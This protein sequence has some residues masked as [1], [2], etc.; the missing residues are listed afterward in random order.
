MREGVCRRSNLADLGGSIVVVALLSWWLR[1]IF[2]P[3]AR[4]RRLPVGPGAPAATACAA[5]RHRSESP[6]AGSRGRRRLFQQSFRPRVKDATRVSTRNR[7]APNAT[8]T[9]SACQ[10][11]RS[12]ARVASSRI[13]NPTPPRRTSSRR[14]R[15]VDRREPGGQSFAIRGRACARVA[16]CAQIMAPD[17]GATRTVAASRAG[18]ETRPADRPVRPASRWALDVSSARKTT[19]VR[20]AGVR[21]M[22]GRAGGYPAAL[23]GHSHF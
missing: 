13:Q 2:A 22:D 17:Q 16:R 4:R 10:P 14:E 21:P 11:S 1:R 23:V 20:R 3:H 7:T 5:I 6:G 9:D 15:I 19:S 8:N 12:S 18:D